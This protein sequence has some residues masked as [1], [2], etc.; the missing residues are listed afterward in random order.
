MKYKVLITK[1]SEVF[2]YVFIDAINDLEAKVMARKIAL[3]ADDLLKENKSEQAK[4]LKWTEGE[5]SKYIITIE[6]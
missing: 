4:S 3:E 6:N 5:R 2:D 1:K